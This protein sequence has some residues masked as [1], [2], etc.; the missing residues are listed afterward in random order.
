MKFK[1]EIL[2]EEADMA[3]KFKGDMLNL[4]AYGLKMG[5]VI[6]VHENGAPEISANPSDYHNNVPHFGPEHKGYPAPTDNYADGD[7]G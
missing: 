3:W 1:I 6:G 2:F 7:E 5:P 4:E